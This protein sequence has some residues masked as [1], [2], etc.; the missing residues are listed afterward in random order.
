MVSYLY[1]FSETRVYEGRSVTAEN[2]SHLLAGLAYKF[3]VTNS[4]RPFT[5][6]L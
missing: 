2:S 4:M 6:I 3:V 1:S 5:G